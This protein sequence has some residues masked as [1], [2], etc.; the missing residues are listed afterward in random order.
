MKTLEASRRL[1]VCT[2]ASIGVTGCAA[3]AVGGAA[4]GAGYAYHERRRLAAFF[5]AESGIV[6]TKQLDD[7]VE[8]Q[9]QAYKNVVIKERG[10]ITLEEVE[11]FRQQVREIYV[12]ELKHYGFLIIDEETGTQ[13]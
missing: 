5:G 6:T 4:A 3:V 1:F 11:R 2:A 12:S 9:V 13:I 8:R 7:A 10:S